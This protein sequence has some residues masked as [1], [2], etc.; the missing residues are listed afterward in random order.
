MT[1]DQGGRPRLFFASQSIE[2]PKVTNLIQVRQMV[3]A[4]AKYCDVTVAVKCGAGRVD[5]PAG[6]RVL[7][8]SASRTRLGNAL[9]GFRV[10]RL[11]QRE[12]VH[13]D[14]VYSRNPLFS[15]C[16]GRL[17]PV[18]VHA[19]EAHHFVG[20]RVASIAQRALFARVDCVVAISEALRARLV[21]FAP[22]LVGRCWVA[23]DAHGNA[24]GAAQPTTDGARP[25]IGYFGK[26]IPSKGVALLKALIPRVPGSDFYVF[27]PSARFGDWPNLIEFRHVPHEHVVHRMKQMDFLLL[28][29]V[30]QDNPRDFSKYTSPLKLFEY[31]SVGGI[32][33][34]S[35]EPVIR[36]VLEHGS[37][38]W[39][40]ANDVDQWAAAIEYLWARP[41][42]R[43]TIRRNAITTARART[44][45]A[46]ARFILDALERHEPARS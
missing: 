16:C 20:G 3:S 27:T 12:A 38:A 32:I 37:N 6:T 2:D 30:P 22:S 45:G 10:Y 18:S 11:F 15:L 35:D 13:Y 34:A 4:F 46:R 41:E 9:F 7:R 28:P 8:V 17:R 21:Q 19:F 29:I 43:E 25:K 5:W 31:L 36:E 26:L 33:V 24:V 14:Y 42:L 44:W 39:L 40:V 23:H 1:R